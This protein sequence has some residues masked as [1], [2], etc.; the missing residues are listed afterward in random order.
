MAVVSPQASALLAHRHFCSAMRSAQHQS[1]RGET[2]HKSL[3]WGGAAAVGPAHRNPCGGAVLWEGFGR[4]LGPVS[5]LASDYACP[6]AVQG[7]VAVRARVQQPDSGAAAKKTPGG[8]RTHMTHCK[9]LFTRREMRPLGGV[10]GDVNTAGRQIR[11][12]GGVDEV[13]TS[14][15]W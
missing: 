10:L 7:L 15:R 5:R 14:R 6:R 12:L 3:P 13:V 1:L 9:S 2:C 8:M 4:R 11:P